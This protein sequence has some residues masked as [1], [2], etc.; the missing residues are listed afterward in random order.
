MWMWNTTRSPNLVTSSSFSS[1]SAW[2]TVGG[3]TYTY[4]THTGTTTVTST[5]TSTLS[6]SATVTES[7]SV[8]FYEQGLVLSTKD[9]GSTAQ[10]G[11]VIT[12]IGVSGGWNATTTTALSSNGTAGSSSYQTIEQLSSAAPA[13][14]TIAQLTSRTINGVASAGTQFSASYSS[15]GTNYNSTTTASTVTYNAVATTTQTQLSTFLSSTTLSETS[16]TTSFPTT[17]TVSYA[18]STTSSSAG[19]ITTSTNSTVT[20]TSTIY[21]TADMAIQSFILDTVIQADTTDWLWSVTN[22]TATD[23]I[24]NIGVTFTRA[25][26]A[27]TNSGGSQAVPTVNLTATSTAWPT[28]TYTAETTYT[29]AQTT[30]NQSS[31]VYT[32]GALPTTTATTTGT[33]TVTTLTLTDSVPLTSTVASTLW[34]VITQSTTNTNN[35]TTVATSTYTSTAFSSGTE[36][37]S[38]SHTG[39]SAGGHTT[40]TGSGSTNAGAT[41]ASATVTYGFPIATLFPGIPPIWLDVTLGQG[42]QATP[43]TF[44]NGQSIGTNISGIPAVTAQDLGNPGV[45]VVPVEGTTAVAIAGNVPTTLLSLYLATQAGGFGFNSTEGTTLTNFP[46]IQRVTTCDSLSNT[47]TAQATYDASSIASTSSLAPGQGQANETV[48]YGNLTTQASPTPP[49]LAFA[50]FPVTV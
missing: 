31:S 26:F 32:F 28:S 19:T 24:T 9:Y 36:S 44:G 17:T 5:T 47:S 13:S 14:Y 43:T 3:T 15:F 38:N 49:F 1:S 16:T 46:G 18:T 27:G 37:T 11:S 50:A 12:K 48:P 35:T 25:T 21:V 42:W 20:V 30:T 33:A 2:T 7:Q 10:P 29:T 8:N 4:T 41:V 40:A 39:T 23:A 45:S 34:Y 22:T 6:S